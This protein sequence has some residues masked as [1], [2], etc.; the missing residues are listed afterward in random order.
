[1]LLCSSKPDV[2]IIVK[3]TEKIFSMCQVLDKVK[4]QS[5][6]QV[7]FRRAQGKCIFVKTFLFVFTEIKLSSR[8]VKCSVSKLINDGLGLK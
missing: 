3:F 2:N 8:E 5:I 1:M 7:I 6:N 4:Q